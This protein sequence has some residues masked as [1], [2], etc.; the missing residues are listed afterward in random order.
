MANIARAFP[1]LFS[2]RDLL[3]LD[4]REVFEWYRL[5]VKSLMTSV[6]VSCNTSNMLMIGDDTR[7][8]LLDATLQKV[9]LSD[10]EGEAQ[11][12]AAPLEDEYQTREEYQKR[13]SL[14]KAMIGGMR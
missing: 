4:I 2:Y 14:A 8:S 3:N 11:T 7:Q 10:D 5:A 1:G 9:V 6:L 12:A 13:F